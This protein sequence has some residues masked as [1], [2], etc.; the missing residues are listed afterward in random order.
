MIGALVK[1]HGVTGDPVA[2][3]LGARF[4]DWE[5]EHG[6]DRDGRILEM[7]GTHLHS[8]CGTCSGIIDLGRALRDYSYVEAGKR[9]YDVGIRPYRTRYGWVK[10]TRSGENGRGEPNNTADLVNAAIYLG[11]AGY[12]QYFQDAEVMIRNLLLRCQIHRTAWVG[13]GGGEADDRE[14]LCTD[15]RRRIRGAFY[16]PTPN[17]VHSYNSDLTGACMQGLCEAWNAIDH[18][19]A[20]GVRVDLLLDKRGESLEIK[21]DLPRT[22]RVLLKARRTRRMHIRIPDWAC[23]G[24]VKVTVTGKPVSVNWRGQYLFLGSVRRGQS[25]RIT[26]PQ[27]RFRTQERAMGWPDTYRL[28][29]VGD[30]VMKIRPRGRICPL[31][32]E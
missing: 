23:R 27:S 4:A 14:T 8:I 12:P 18:H 7:A 21:S 11:Q 2:L 26:F 31:F 24:S 6:F 17:D 16:F 15:V 22:G 28:E 1:Y 25:V 9:I 3:E 29:W 20:D 10:E 32:P 5:L 30:T 13:D 19:E